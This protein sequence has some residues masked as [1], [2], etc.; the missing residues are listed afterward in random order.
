MNRTASPTRTAAE[1]NTR[2][3]TA[4]LPA[5]L[6]DHALSV[7]G[8][9]ITDTLV[10]GLEMVRR[11]GAATSARRLRGRLHLDIDLDASRERRRR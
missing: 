3:V 7:T 8:M 10:E 1:Q 6:L 2:R 4:N 9:G 5:A 11:R